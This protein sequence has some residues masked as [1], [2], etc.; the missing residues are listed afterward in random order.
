LGKIASPVL[1]HPDHKLQSFNCGNSTLDEW[2]VKR[3]LKNHDS[4][5]SRTFVICDEGNSVIG[6]YALATGSIE[7]DVA[8][9]NFSRSMPEPIP[10]IMLGRLAIDQNYQGKRLGAGLLKDAMVRTLA[11]TSTI[12][13]RGLLVHAI[14][15]E[16]K[17][18]YLQY[19][20]Q[21]SPVDS[22]TLMLSTKNIRKHFD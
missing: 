1:L 10:V 22:M 5:A 9:K 8:T 12:G 13:A 15:E 16:A 11:V 17:R 19:G 3:A 4:G 18:F 14:S 7:R 21:E 2:L 6:Y 20:F